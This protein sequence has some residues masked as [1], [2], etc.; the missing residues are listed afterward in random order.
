MMT[1]QTEEALKIRQ[2]LDNPDLSNNERMWEVSLLVD[3][4]LEQ[5]SVAELNDEYLRD[6]HVEGLQPTPPCQECENLKH[7]LEGYMEA[8]K[9]L[10]N[11]EWVG[12]SDEEI[13][14][15]AAQIVVE[16]HYKEKNNAV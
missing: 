15:K 7:D 11:R 12:L 8:N 6:T 1:K 5:P 10:I 3:E 14:Q 2:I 4:V 13:L 16:R 9:A